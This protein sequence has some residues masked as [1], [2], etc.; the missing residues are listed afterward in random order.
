M[1]DPDYD[2]DATLV[3]PPSH[4]L[5][6]RLYEVNQVVTR[7]IAVMASDEILQSIN[8]FIKVVVDTEAELDS[9]ITEW[10][11]TT[12]QVSPPVY[13]NHHNGI[14]SQPPTPPSPPLALPPQP[15]PTQVDLTTTDTTKPDHTFDI[16]GFEPANVFFLTSDREVLSSEFS[17]GPKNKV[18]TPPFSP[19]GPPRRQNAV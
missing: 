18:F 5:A 15:P 16:S 19:G 8:F 9:L 10:E 6:V 17:F 3:N 14:P 13:Q 12:L 1:Q 2:G 4:E 7:T 11:A